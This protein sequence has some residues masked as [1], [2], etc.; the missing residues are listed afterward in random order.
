M[1]S[2]EVLA[3]HS[4]GKVKTL[5]KKVLDPNIISDIIN[6]VSKRCDVPH[7]PVQ[8]AIR[9]KCIEESKLMRQRMKNEK[10][11]I[12][13]TLDELQMGRKT[14]QNSNSHTPKA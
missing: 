9:A 13:R 11:E 6:Y 2:H 1:F 12:P 5:G 10:E 7:E 4:F 8:Y 3:T 14:V